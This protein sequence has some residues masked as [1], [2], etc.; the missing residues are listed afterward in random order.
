MFKTIKYEHFFFH[1][2]VLEKSNILRPQMFECFEK[3]ARKK[4]RR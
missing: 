3:I 2:V 4:K 1:L